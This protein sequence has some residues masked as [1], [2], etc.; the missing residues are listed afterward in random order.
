MHAGE[1]TGKA[2]PPKEPVDVE[3]PNIFSDGESISS[4]E[5]V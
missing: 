5:S 2:L 3:F 1:I 4:S